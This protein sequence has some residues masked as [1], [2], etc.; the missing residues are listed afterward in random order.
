MSTEVKHE[1]GIEVKH[2]FWVEG[3]PPA[4]KMANDDDGYYIQTFIGW[5]EVER[6]IQTMRAEAEKVFGPNPL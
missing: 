4:L 2:E 6:F 3:E 1:F 5:K